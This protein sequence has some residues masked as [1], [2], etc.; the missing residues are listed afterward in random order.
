MPHLQELDLGGGTEFKATEAGL[1]AFVQ[2]CPELLSLDV[3]WDDVTPI[4][5][6]GYDRVEAMVLERRKRLQKRT[7]RSALN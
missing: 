7:D 1:L 2:N 3:N 4:S 5:K 6:Q